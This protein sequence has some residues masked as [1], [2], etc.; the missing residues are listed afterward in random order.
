MI[1]KKLKEATRDQH[2]AL[3]NVVD[4][5]SSTFTRDDYIGLITKFYTFYAAIEPTLPAASLATAGFDIGPRSKTKM[6]ERDLKYLGAFETAVSTPAWAD[7]P[8]LDTTARA[9][10]SIYVM[11]GATLGGQLITRQLKENLGITPENGGAFF[12]SYGPNVGPMWKQFGA[13]I[14][15]FA[16]TADDDEAIVAAARETFD[17]FRRCFQKAEVPE[18]AQLF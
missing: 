2:E 7:I 18:T 8:K 5:M 6:L 13:A 17:S 9:F 11:E 12:N 3:E 10:G 15:V 14:T 16:E 1:L 4:V